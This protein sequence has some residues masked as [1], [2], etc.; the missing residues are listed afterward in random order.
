[1]IHNS[2]PHAGPANS[3][4][5]PDPVIDPAAN[6]QKTADPAVDPIT[7]ESAPE[8]SSSSGS[9]PPPPPQDP[10]TDS[11]SS[12]S[13]SPSLPPQKP[14]SEAKLRAN[15]ANARKSTGPRTPEGKRR[16]RLN[17]LKHGLRSE[18]MLLPGED[19][20]A[21]EDL[22]RAYFDEKQPVGPSEL[23]LTERIFQAHWRMRRLMR[24][25][26]DLYRR[27]IPKGRSFQG[28]Y[29]PENFDPSIQNL[30]GMAWMDLP[31]GAKTHPFLLIIRYETSIERGL[32]HN[33][34]QL[35]A[36]QSR[37][38]MAEA[39]GRRSPQDPV[40][41]YPPDHGLQQEF[42]RIVYSKPEPVEP[43]RQALRQKEL[44]LHQL[45]NQ[46]ARARSQL[47]LVGLLG[48]DNEILPFYTKPKNQSGRPNVANFPPGVRPEDFGLPSEED[49][50]QK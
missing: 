2:V 21:F 5:A 9:P 48:K 41:C 20:Q 24:A 42:P 34:Q 8:E 39:L 17:A 11:S 28:D 46:L 10:P 36:L 19:A 50:E 31:S 45:H 35:A 38:R 13:S 23:Y 14:I 33:A 22:K 25:E 18:E 27:L 3:T 26:A 12:P 37:R 7:P 47:Q 40:P 29:A 15:R 1:M 30:G 43:I 4:P 16:V 6:S 44:E 49:S 32:H